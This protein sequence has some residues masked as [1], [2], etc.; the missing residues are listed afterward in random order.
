PV[1][2]RIDA[3]WN[4]FTNYTGGLLRGDEGACNSWDDNHEVLIVGFGTCDGVPCWKIKNSWGATWGNNGYAYLERG[5]GYDGVCGVEKY[6]YYPVF[7][8]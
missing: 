4:A 3:K 2:A 5:Y 1:V 8:T 6:G 7:T